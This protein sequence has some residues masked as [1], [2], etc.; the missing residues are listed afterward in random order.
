MFL[1]A[2]VETQLRNVMEKG[3]V[4]VCIQYI[5]IFRYVKH[6]TYAFNIV[7]FFEDESMHDIL[8]LNFKTLRY[9]SSCLVK[10]PR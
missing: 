2:C 6:V 10:L 1:K 4:F 7:D 5:C 8:V 9:N 3:F